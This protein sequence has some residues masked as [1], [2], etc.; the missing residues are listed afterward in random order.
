MTDNAAVEFVPSGKPLATEPTKTPAEKEI[1]AHLQ[2]IR[3]NTT[4]LATLAVIGFLASI[5]VG[6]IV[7][8]QVSH[9]NSNLSGNS[10]GGGI[11]NCQSQGGTDPSC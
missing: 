7:A 8:V 10:G 1:I 3:T 5:I 6:V 4:I 2:Q 11:S 9:L